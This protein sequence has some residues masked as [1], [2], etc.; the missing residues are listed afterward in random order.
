MSPNNLALAVAFIWLLGSVVLIGRS[1][2]SGSI[3]AEAL[4]ARHPRTYED[5]GRPRPT[6][7]ESIRRVRFFRF[8]LRREYI[9]LNDPV[10]QPQFEHYRSE[11]LRRLMFIASGGLATLVALLWAHYA[12]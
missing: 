8:V 7:F 6:Y 3:L 11:E 1:V 12:A 2:R 9:L 5:L 4:A 10:L